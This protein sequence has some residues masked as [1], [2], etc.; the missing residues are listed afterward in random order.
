MQLNMLK[1]ANQ[2]KTNLGPVKEVQTE[3]DI[4]P[5][6]FVHQMTNI[7]EVQPPL[8]QDAAQNLQ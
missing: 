4:D 2:L 1:K 8:Q 5:Q 3:Q 6:N 7:V